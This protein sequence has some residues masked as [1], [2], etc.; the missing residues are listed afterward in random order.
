MISEMK[1]FFDSWIEKKEVNLGSVIVFVPNVK[2]GRS[3]EKN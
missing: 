3:L 2:T 1:K